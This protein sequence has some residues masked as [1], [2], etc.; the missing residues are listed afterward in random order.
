MRWGVFAIALA[1][2]L[3]LDGAFMSVFAIGS[4]RPFLT[5]CLVVFVCLHAQRHIG[6]W[7]ALLAGL[8]VDVTSPAL[9]D[10]TVPYILIGPTALG[11]VFGSQLAL[12]LRSMVVR[13]NPL[14]VGVLVCLF[15]LASMLVTTA[16]H[17]VR[18]WY[19]GPLPPW[20]PERSALSYLGIESLRAVYSGLIAIV[21][22]LPLNAFASLFGFTAAAPW[23]PRRG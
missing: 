4:M 11:F 9:F 14:A 17:S 16:I 18:G 3:V 22:I 23:T 8:A 13:R 21:A 6:L 15:A 2:T 7:A 10:G 12:P 1:I 5:P 20:M 19:T